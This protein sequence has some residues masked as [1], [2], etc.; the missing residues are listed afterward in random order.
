MFPYRLLPGAAS[1]FSQLLPATH[2]MNAFLGLSMGKEADFSPLGSV[3]VLVFGGLL[4]FLL[5]IYLFSWDSQNLT[6]KGNR[7]LAALV[8]APYLAGMLLLA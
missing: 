2:A 7:L 4:A 1:T 5:S 8:L 6:R 3:S